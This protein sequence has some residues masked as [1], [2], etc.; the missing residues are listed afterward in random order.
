MKWLDA[1]LSEKLG[2]LIIGTNQLLVSG[3]DF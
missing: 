1:K 3:F 2:W